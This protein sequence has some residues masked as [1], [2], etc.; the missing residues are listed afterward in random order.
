MTLHETQTE[1]L[2]KLEQALER[3]SARSRDNPTRVT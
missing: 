3:V 2:F 1:H